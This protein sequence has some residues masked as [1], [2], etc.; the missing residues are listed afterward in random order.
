MLRLDRVMEDPFT[1]CIV[2][3]PA[4][5]VCR[6]LW[7]NDGAFSFASFGFAGA[8]FSLTLIMEGSGDFQRTFFFIE[9]LPLQAADLSAAQ[10]GGQLRVEEIVPRPSFLSL[11]YIRCTSVV[12][13]CEIRL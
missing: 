9:V 10:S 2:F 11:I 12:V 8:V 13:I 6:A 3:T 1:Q 7:Q 5:Q 4:Q